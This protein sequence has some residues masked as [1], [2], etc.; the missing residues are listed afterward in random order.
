MADCDTK[1]VDVKR[2]KEADE[3][4]T[5]AQ[6]EAKLSDSAKEEFEILFQF[7]SKVFLSNFPIYRAYKC[8]VQNP[9]DDLSPK[10][11]SV[12]GNFCEMTVST[13]NPT[14]LCHD[15]VMLRCCCRVLQCAFQ[16]SDIVTS[17]MLRN[18]H[19]FCDHGGFEA[20]VKCFHRCSPKQL[21]C[22]LASE[23]VL[24]VVNVSDDSYTITRLAV[25]S[26]CTL[27]IDFYSR[28]R[29]ACG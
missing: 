17:W 29:S 14:Y 23:L 9:L 7:V 18:I 22:E 26:Q 11:V 28:S 27:I 15:D 13:A 21:P 1:P 19:Y 3:A 6:P 5:S 8:I 20:L 2:V 12:L 25:K 4:G 10:E 24:I 16:E